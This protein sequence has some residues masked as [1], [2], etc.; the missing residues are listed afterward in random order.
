[1]VLVYGSWSVDR[2]RVKDTDLERSQ[3]IV[4]D[5][6]GMKDRSTMLPEELKLFLETHLERVKIIHER[7]LT[8]GYGEVYL[9]FG[10][11]RKYPNAAKE[12]GWQ[13]VFPSERI[14][15][16]PR[17]GKIRRHHIDESAL[18]KAML[19]ADRMASI[20]RPADPHTLRHS[21]ATHLWE[22]GMISA[23]YR[24]CL[25]IRTCPSR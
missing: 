16:D 4:R 13:Y 5:G 8:D 23:R 12:W 7:D 6:K 15:N 25:G 14:S 20:T 11:A 9:P 18:Q 1:M 10:L 17:S 24:S 19:R 22:R 3:M 2:L 21:F